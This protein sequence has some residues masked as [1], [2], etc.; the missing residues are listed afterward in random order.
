MSNN[1][2]KSN[3][4][5]FKGQTKVYKNKKHAINWFENLKNVLEP[6]SLASDI[7]EKIDCQ[8]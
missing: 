3:N 8:C 4:L 7:Q 1:I 6:K 5:T 2:F